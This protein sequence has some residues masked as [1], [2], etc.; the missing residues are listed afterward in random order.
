LGSSGSRKLKDVLIDRRIP[1]DDRGRLPLLV[2][3]GKIVWVPG[4]TV[5]ED[6]RLRHDGPCWVAFLEPLKRFKEAY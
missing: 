4:V 5:D 2:H 1:A 6:F 3:A